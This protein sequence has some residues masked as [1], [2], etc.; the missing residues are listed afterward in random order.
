MSIVCAKG[1]RFRYRKPYKKRS[2]WDSRS[3]GFRNYESYLKSDLWESIRDAK[4]ARHPGC[5]CCGGTA[6]EVHHFSYY[7]DVI[8]GM[9]DQKL[10]SV[11]HECHFDIEFT[12]G[13][14]NNLKQ[15]QQKLVSRLRSLGKKSRVNELKTHYKKDGS[16]KPKANTQ[17]KARLEAAQREKDTI[18]REDEHNKRLAAVHAARAANKNLQKMGWPRKLKKPRKVKRDAAKCVVLNISDD[19]MQELSAKRSSAIKQM[20]ESR[21]SDVGGAYE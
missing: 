1:A 4:L 18:A 21:R 11:C 20:I 13:K 14:K 10:V 17:S 16:V 8:L 6:T 5:E 12:D 7:R 2:G 19:R 3:T 9:C 15:A